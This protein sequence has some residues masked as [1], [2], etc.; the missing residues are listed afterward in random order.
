MILRIVYKLVMMV[1]QSLRTFRLTD[2][3]DKGSEGQGTDEKK[4]DKKEDR[5][6]NRENSRGKR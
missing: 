1:I 4:K 5:R 6:K 3:I 2:S